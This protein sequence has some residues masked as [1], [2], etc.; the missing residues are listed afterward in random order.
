MAAGPQ[1]LGE[2]HVHSNVTEDD[3]CGA[4]GLSGLRRGLHT[5]RGPTVQG[6]AT[7]AAIRVNSAAG[8][9]GR[10]WRDS[11]SHGSAP[12]P[13]EARLGML[14]PGLGPAPGFLRSRANRNPRGDAA[15]PEAT[16]ATRSGALGPW[17]TDA[18]CRGS[19]GHTPASPQLG[20]R[21]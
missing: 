14:R 20:A 17:T 7:E 2:G 1:S 13:L 16:R 5:V 11:G 21:A 6:Q 8:R 9:Q 4:N 10:A 12:R 15:L 18:V 19:R 3:V